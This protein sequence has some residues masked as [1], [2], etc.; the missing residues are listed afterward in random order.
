MRRRLLMSFTVF[1]VAACGATTYT[2]YDPW[3]VVPDAGADGGVG[4]VDAGRVDSG[5][6]FDAGAPRDAGPARDAGVPTDSGVPRDAG[7]ACGPATCTGCCSASG[8]EPGNAV[9]GCGKGGGACSV[10]AGDQVCGPAQTCGTDPNTQWLVQ[11]TSAV[12]SDSYDAFSGPDTEVDVWCPA[13]SGSNT[14]TPVVD[15]STTPTWSTGGCVA[16]SG[17]LLSI[18]FAYAADDYD[19]VTSNDTIVGKTTVPV[20]ASDLQAGQVTV[21]NQGGVMSM[22]FTLTKQ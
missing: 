7:V 4:R 15:D 10:C 8:C 1:A 12:I 21:T 17:D 2:E 14:T 5:V 16:S 6:P 20:T 22:T 9:T 13:T 19:G 18:G 11:P 3:L